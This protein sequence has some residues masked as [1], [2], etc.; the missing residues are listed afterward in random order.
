M[1]ECILPTLRHKECQEQKIPFFPPLIIVYAELVYYA[2]L[3]VMKHSKYCKWNSVEEKGKKTQTTL[4][5]Q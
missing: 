2:D 1:D 3:F 5:F 4:H